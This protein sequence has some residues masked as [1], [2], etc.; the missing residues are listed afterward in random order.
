MFSKQLHV[1]KSL[2]RDVGVMVLQRTGSDLGVMEKTSHLDFVTRIDRD[3]EEMIREGLRFLDDGHAFIGEEDERGPEAQYE[4]LRSLEPDRD[5]WIVDPID[6]TTNFVMGLPTYAVSI[7]LMRNRTL[8]LGVVYSP[9]TDELF[10]GE[11]GRG[12]WLDGRRLAVARTGLL[13]DALIGGGVPSTDL[14]KRRETMRRLVRLAPDCFNLRLH[15]C[16]SLTLAAVAAGRLSGMFET[17][18]KVWDIAAGALLV[19]EAGGR[20]SNFAGEA[21]EFQDREVVATNGSIHDELLRYTA[22]PA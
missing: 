6:G 7:A 10:Y 15:G 4:S 19:R 1:A 9:V 16:A 2:A 8:E 11:R 3:A 21:W 5:A 12:A 22:D 18:L 13:R 14:D 20:V 17:H